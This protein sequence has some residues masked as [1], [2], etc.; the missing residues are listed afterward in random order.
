MVN[1]KEFLLE[2]SIDFG[3]Y[4]LVTYNDK[5]EPTWFSK[6]SL[7]GIDWFLESPC[8]LYKITEIK[9]PINKFAKEYVD[10]LLEE[11]E[12]IGDY[13]NTYIRPMIVNDVLYEIE[14]FQCSPYL[15]ECVDEIKLISR[16]ECLE[17]MLKQIEE[18]F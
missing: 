10:G 12:D 9:E 11:G 18:K 17:Y 15:P 1:V 2:N 6:Y 7:E 13:I 5:T 16:R 3:T 14:N 4:A 8:E